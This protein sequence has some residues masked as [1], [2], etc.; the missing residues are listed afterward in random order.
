M[1]ISLIILLFVF[2]GC[3]LRNAQLPEQPSRSVFQHNPYVTRESKLFIL[4][5]LLN[6]T[7]TLNEGLEI[8]DRRTI[9]K[10][11]KL[12]CFEN[13][14]TAPSLHSKLILANGRHGTTLYTDISKSVF[15]GPGYYNHPCSVNAKKNPLIPLNARPLRYTKLKF[16]SRESAVNAFDCLFI[17]DVY[18]YQSRIITEQWWEFSG[19]TVFQLTDGE[20]LKYASIE[21]IR[22][23]IIHAN[24]I[25]Y[26]QIVNIRRVNELIEYEILSDGVLEKEMK[27]STIITPYLPFTEFDITILGEELKDVKEILDAKGI[28]YQIS[29]ART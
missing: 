20:R 14:D 15:K 1:R 19:K 18:I 8:T 4:P 11:S 27:N 26:H 17:N 29:S 3:S 7:S 5:L 23:Y 13:L 21:A 25:P 22:N 2:T 10:L 12:K 9:K 6:D 24:N 28:A 16:D